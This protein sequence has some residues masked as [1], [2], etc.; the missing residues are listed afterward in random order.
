M[1]LSEILIIMAL[2]FSSKWRISESVNGKRFF[3]YGT[4]FYSCWYWRFNKV[5]MEISDIEFN[6]WL[7]RRLQERAADLSPESNRTSKN[8]TTQ[9]V[10]IVKPPAQQPQDVQKKSLL[11]N[12]LRKATF[13]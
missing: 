6:L 7:S 11:H 3:E 5:R 10:Y 12:L 9:R 13:I 8:G 1:F 4:R 2:Y